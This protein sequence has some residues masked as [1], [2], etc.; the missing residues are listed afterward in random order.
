MQIEVGIDKTDIKEIVD[1][2]TALV[3]EE[4]RVSHQDTLKRVSEIIDRGIHKKSGYDGEEYILLR[5]GSKYQK[6]F[7]DDIIFAETFERKII[8]HTKSEDIEYYGKLVD[9]EKVLG[10]RFFRTHRA[11]LVNLEH[12][13][14][15]DIESVQL[16]K[17]EAILSKA[18][19][20]AFSEVIK[21][22]AK[23]F[24]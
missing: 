15:F 19:Y 5:R 14:S 17:G 7:F 24:F 11:Y 18:K 6:I 1:E 21:E 12:V 20:H 4:V 22:R 8:I 13:L 23:V 16:I 9:L 2:I 3:P 10:E